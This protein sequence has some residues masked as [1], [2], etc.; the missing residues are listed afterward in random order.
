ME[1]LVSNMSSVKMAT[2]QPVH[3]THSQFRQKHQP[4]NPSTAVSYKSMVGFSGN[5]DVGSVANSI[6]ET[7]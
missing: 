2:P 3:M 5:K 1:D 7:A 6:A 4:L